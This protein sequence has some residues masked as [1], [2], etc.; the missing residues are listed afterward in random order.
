M[1]TF[2]PEEQQQ[3]NLQDNC[4]IRL[5]PLNGPKR[6]PICGCAPVLH[7]VVLAGVIRLRVECG[8]PACAQAPTPW[9]NHSH[10]VLRHWNLNAVLLG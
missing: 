7:R 3:L 4:L 8:N 2:P 5:T 1:V 10:Q 6:C 9:M